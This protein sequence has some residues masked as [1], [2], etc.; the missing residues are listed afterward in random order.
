MGVTQGA[1][2]AAFFLNNSLRQFCASNIQV[3][4]GGD[5]R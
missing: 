1:L 4:A 5:E 2:E 3:M